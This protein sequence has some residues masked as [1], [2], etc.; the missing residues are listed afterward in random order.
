MNRIATV[1]AFLS[2]FAPSATAQQLTIT[3]PIS[4]D[5]TQEVI[6]LPL[7]RVLEA[8]HLAGNSHPGQAA[9]IAAIDAGTGKLIP[10]QLYASRPDASPD[11]FLL[12]VQLPAHGS[13]RILFKAQNSANTITPLVF[14]RAV[15]ERKDD[16]AWENQLVTFRIY[17][18]ALQATGEVSSGVD[19]WSKRIPSF[20]ID[21]FYKRDSEGSIT[22]NPALSYHKDNG[23][24]LDS[25]DVG[26]TPG[27]GGTAVYAGGKL[28]P[29]RN[30]TNVRILANGPIRFAFEITYAPWDANGVMVS[31]TRRVV[32]DAGTH[33]NRIESTYTWQGRQ[34]LQLSA[35]VA[36]HKDAQTANPAKNEIIAVW[37]TP[38]DATA[39][40]IAT[41]LLALPQQ[42]ATSIEEP[43][44][45]LLLFTRHSGEP[46]IYYAGAGWSKADMP[47]STAWNQYLITQLDILEHPLQLH[48]QP[49]AQHQYGTRYK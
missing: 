36:V 29:S 16:F 47:T 28:Y 18:P 9:K 42:H 19:V 23:V 4:I 22:H 3:N 38:Q 8:A 30:Y 12:L 2:A 11:T 24:G 48:W 37:D 10:S 26:P 15:P 13:E 17:G 43:G 6:E 20:I 5:R 1:L 41:G 49:A 44:H 25:Y 40:H 33:L 7:A 45:N 46:F 21:D 27:C 14:G 34:A 32:L 39:G 31:E 35:G